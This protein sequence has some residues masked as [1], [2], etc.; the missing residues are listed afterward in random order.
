MATLS[1]NQIPST[2][3]FTSPSRG[4]EQWHGAWDVDLS[5]FQKLDK[6]ER[7]RWYQFETGQGQ[8]NWSVLDNSIHEAMDRGG[9]FGFGIMTVCDCDTNALLEIGGKYASYPLYLHNLMQGESTK[10]TLIGNHWIP[11]WNSNAYLTNLE[12][13]LKD[14]NTHLETTFYKGVK[15]ANAIS[16]IDIRGYGQ[17]GEWHLSGIESAPAA[18][19]TSLKRIVDAHL[20]G[21]P[22]QRLVAM[23]AALNG[24]SVNWDV[25]PV[26]ADVSYYILTAKNN[27]GEIGWRRD[28]LGS[29]EAYLPLML[30]NNT[31]TYN[32]LAFKTAI[33]NKW[34]TAPIVGE[35]NSG[36]DM[37]LL[38]SQVRMYHMM[39]FGNGNYN[40]PNG[41]SSN[42]ISVIKSSALAAGYR[43]TI[44]GGSVNLTSTQ[45][46]VALNW[47]NSGLTPTYEK[48][49]V[50]YS[51]K[52][53]IGEVVW[54]GVSS[55]TPTLF[56]PGTKTVSD[57]FTVQIPDGTYTL[58]MKI[59]DPTGYRKAL[60]LAISGQLTDGS[61]ILAP[62]LTVSGSTTP[63]T[64][65]PPTT[66]TT[67]TTT[68]KAPTT[69]T[70]TTTTRPPVIVQPSILSVQIN[71][72]DGTSKII[73]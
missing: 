21:F 32:G 7:F 25:F 10:D 61:Y 48:W 9:K 49:N 62:A 13:F 8:Y 65:L 68:T 30:E 27:A 59:T 66:T 51:L 16:Y 3:N 2:T 35:P 31:V 55:F 54:K 50:E 14:I 1:F 58:S 18:T 73:S 17:W 42:E 36:V 28:S 29:G 56:L 33:M 26:P 41:L 69:S 40:S 67:T 60:P 72:T 23:I 22:N 34:K 6:Y 70:T 15:L 63:P 64:T 47:T 19:S 37:D 24:Q 11:N 53:S 57:A 4:A 20:K 38:L 52:N 12:R 46:N 43:I 39:S 45:L 71:F 44:T 5:P